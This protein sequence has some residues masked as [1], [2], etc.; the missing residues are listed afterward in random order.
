METVHEASACNE[1]K[2]E[3]LKAVK[4]ELFKLVRCALAKPLY[5][6][7]RAESAIVAAAIPVL[8]KE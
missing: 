3:E 2:P 8:F 7:D 4:Y 5:E 6:L 1:I